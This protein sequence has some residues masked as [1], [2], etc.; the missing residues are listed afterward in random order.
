[1]TRLPAPKTVRQKLADRLQ[2][3]RERQRQRRSLASLWE[4]QYGHGAGKAHPSVEF[5]SCPHCQSPPAVLCTGP[6]GAVFGAH[7]LRK[8]AYRDLKAK[9]RAAL[10]EPRSAS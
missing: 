9:V 8:Y 10:P 5:V 4:G 3:D 6:R 1:M 7:Y 2:R